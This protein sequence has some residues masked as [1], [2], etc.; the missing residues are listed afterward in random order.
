[1][2]TPRPTV[3]VTRRLPAPV[4]LRLMELF[5]TRLNHQDIPLSRD[6]LADAMR[7]ADGLVT[8]VTDRIDSELLATGPRRLTII[9]NFGV[10]YEHIDIDAAHRHGVVVTNTPGVV[11]DDTA[12]LAMALILAVARRVGEGE[13]LVRAGAW[14]GWN[15]TQL[16]GTKV[17]GST[18]GIIGMGRIGQ[19]LARRAH[20]GFGMPIVYVNRSP[21][22]TDELNG[23]DAEPC[24]SI[25]ELL[26]RSDV[27]SL[28]LPSTPQ[29]RH[30]IDARRLALMRPGALLI[31]TGRGDLIDTQAL[32][33]ALQSGTITGA[34]L[35]VFEGEPHVDGALRSLNNVVLLP[36][37]G[38]A[39]T[40]TRIA[41]GN[42]AVDNLVAFFAG[43][44]CPNHID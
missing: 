21:I 19:A 20:L 43:T 5:D 13:R 28:H 23:L 38:S 31:N 30:L 42:C 15:P 4:E 32:V 27:V 29:T 41:M 35:D 36:H 37:L 44:H 34:G 16:L 24:G 14:S 39:T 17:T 26:A 1:M 11:T 2:T 7:H 22:R 3:V 6:D 12:D 10:G 9:A 40:T 25:D 18:L 33:N 8:T